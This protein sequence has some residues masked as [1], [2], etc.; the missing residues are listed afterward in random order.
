VCSA[1]CGT[2]CR[3]TLF[4]VQYPPY[5]CLQQPFTLMCCQPTVEV[6]V[7]GIT[8]GLVMFIAILSCTAPVLYQYCIPWLLHMLLQVRCQHSS[9]CSCCS[10]SVLCLLIPAGPLTSSRHSWLRC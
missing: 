9:C 10:S 5:F 1:S 3:Q 7:I 8:E 4:N 6:A 2:M